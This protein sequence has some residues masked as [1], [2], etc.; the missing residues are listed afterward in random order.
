MTT[1]YLDK[2]G[3]LLRTDPG[4]LPQAPDSAP[5]SAATPAAT[6][7]AATPSTD[8]APVMSGRKNTSPES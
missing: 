2:T 7:V 8:A 5:A 3:K 4:T 6:P 1:R